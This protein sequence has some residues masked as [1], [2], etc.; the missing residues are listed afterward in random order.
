MSTKNINDVEEEKVI[1]GNDVKING[2]GAV[3]SSEQNYCGVVPETERASRERNDEEEEEREER[4]GDLESHSIGAVLSSVQNKCG[5]VPNKV[6][7]SKENRMNTEEEE[8]RIQSD[9]G[10]EGSDGAVLSSVQK[11]L[12]VVPYSEN[13]LIVTLPNSDNRKRKAGEEVIEEE[14]R[15]VRAPVKYIGETSRSGYER[16]REHWKDFE[17]ISVKS[18]MLKHYFEKHKDKE[19]KEMKF[20]VKV[21][22]SYRSAFERQIGES[23]HIN[24]NLKNGTHLLNSKNEYNRCIIPRLGIHLDKDEMVEEYEENEK[25][26][27]LKR[28]IQKLKESIRYEKKI[29]KSKKM[30]LL[31]DDNR[32]TEKQKKGVSFEVKQRK[33]RWGELVV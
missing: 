26:K 22:K 33:K 20:S 21:L 5:V 1:I 30:K 24:H 6:R 16:M 9:R 12:G 31:K 13:K 17:N 14:K 11:N 27:E 32:E 15:I 4:S 19:R 25:E 29:Q 8:E 10:G 28:E 7:A 18:H 3:L 23:V 2:K